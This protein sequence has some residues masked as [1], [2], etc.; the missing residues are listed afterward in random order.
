MEHSAAWTEQGRLYTW[1]AGEDGR[2]GHGDEENRWSPS[3]VGGALSNETV[4][5]V[6]AGSSHT[7]AV[8]ASGALYAWGS[9]EKGQLCTG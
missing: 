6:A 8:C 5:G 7:V 4:I 3:L 9:N 2:L 1:G